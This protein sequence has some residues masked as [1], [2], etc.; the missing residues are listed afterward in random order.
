MEQSEKKNVIDEAEEV[1]LLQQLE[2]SKSQQTKFPEDA[3]RIYVK[4]LWRKV[5]ITLLFHFLADI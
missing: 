2:V 3:E 4:L 1:F 5:N